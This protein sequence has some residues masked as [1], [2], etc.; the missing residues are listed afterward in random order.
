M[1]SRRIVFVNAILLIAFFVLVLFPAVR[2]DDKLWCAASAV[3]SSPWTVHAC[4]RPRRVGISSTASLFAF[5]AAHFGFSHVEMVPIL[6]FG[7]QKDL[8]IR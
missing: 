8:P 3:V 7:Q 1:S 6:W 5:F 4:L 2:E